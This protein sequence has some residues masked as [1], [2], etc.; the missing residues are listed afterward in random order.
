MNKLLLTLSA[1]MLVF[2][3]FS[4]NS[5]KPL[6][7]GNLTGTASPAAVNEGTVEKIPVTR[8]RT[9][10]LTP[11]KETFMAMFDGNMQSTWF[12]GW[13]AVYPASALTDLNGTYTITRIRLRN[14]QGSRQFKIY[15]GDTPLDTNLIFNQVLTIYNDWIDVNLNHPGIK[16]LKFEIPGN[17]TDSPAELEI[18]GIK[19]GTSAVE[20]PTG[21]FR[22][23]TSTNGIF[24]VNGFHW[25]DPSLETP[26]F[27]LREFVDAQ[28]IQN[29]KDKYRYNP[30]ASGGGMLD[31]HYAQLKSLGFEVMPVIQGNLPWTR[32]AE[33]NDKDFKPVYPVNADPTQPASYKDY[34]E[35]LFQFAA[36]YGY[37]NVDPALLKIDSVPRWTGD[38]VQVKKSGLGLVKYFECLNEPDKYWKGTKGYMSPFELAAF[39]SVA[40]DGH[41][42]SMGPGIGIKNA[43]PSAKVVL[44]GLTQISLDYIKAMVMWFKAYRADGKIPVDAFN[45]HFYPN[46]S[47]FQHTAGSVGISPEASRLREKLVE[48]KAYL[49]A[50][51]P[52]KEIFLSEYGYDSNTGSPQRCEPI[53]SMDRREVQGIWNVRL[54]MDLMAAQIDK[55]Y[56]Y[57]MYDEATTDDNGGTFANCGVTTGYTAGSEKK[58]AWYYIN[59]LKETLKDCKFE[60]DQSTDPRIRR[61]K[62][63]KGN[64]T[65]YSIW[66]TTSKDSSGTYILN[67]PGMTSAQIIQLAHQM[68][69]GTSSNVS[70]TGNLSLQISER[71]IFVVTENIPP[72]INTGNGLQATYFNSINLTGSSISR[73]DEKIDFDW[74]LNSPLTGINSNSFS[75]RWTG[76]VQAEFS[77]PCTFH[78]VSDDGV[79]LWIDNVLV[80]DNWTY[81]GTTENSATVNLTAGQKYPVKMEYFEGNGGAVAKLLWS[82]SSL[83]K[84]P[85]PKANLYSSPDPGADVIVITSSEIAQEAMPAA[86][87]YPNPFT[88]EI[89]I[90]FNKEL[91]NY[92]IELSDCTGSIIY[93]KSG[94]EGNRI[95]LTAARLELKTGVY[96]VK[97]TDDKNSVQVLKL[98]KE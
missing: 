95:V 41:C 23:V 69:S 35:F 72:V 14:F 59:T 30:T 96:F 20:P 80:I 94:F 79:R 57:M 45:F 21:T 77:G 46:T 31:D 34:G 25:V 16:Y 56:L 28:F 37:T 87:V 3:A 91:T 11:Q 71:P 78:T 6:S 82:G 90:T 15:G 66:L 92:R 36:R 64:K 5:T 75:T 10:L 32:T 62:F 63:S 13:E 17:K 42:N 88:D 4:N 22:P 65:I 68:P 18:Y 49:D 73:I 83:I 85:V 2:Q 1:M 67:L 81:H 58:K 97:I 70:F 74:G 53:G 86:L 12:P 19:T 9:I 44:S 51:F 54:M 89:T 38:P 61:Y 52:G 84:Q 7:W 48:I 47:G 40:A 8:D 50:H 76:F 27:T 24:G 43:D 29:Q 26:F 60:S 39:L 93:E 33:Y 55:S 98:I